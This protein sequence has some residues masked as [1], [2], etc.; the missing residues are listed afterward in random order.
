MGS[1]MGVESALRP[2]PEPALFDVDLA[3][4]PQTV[5]VTEPH[6]GAGLRIEVAASVGRTASANF[7]ESTAHTV[8][9]H[10]PSLSRQGHGDVAGHDYGLMVGKDARLGEGRARGDGNGGDVANG[11]DARIGGLQGL[12][13]N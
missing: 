13:V 12:R 7:N 11:I 4:V 9:S 10:R 1:L 2:A 5:G 3:V 6:L 8:E